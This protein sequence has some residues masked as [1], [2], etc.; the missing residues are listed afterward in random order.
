[1]AL[2]RATSVAQLGRAVGVAAGRLSVMVLS[3]GLAIALARI[4]PPAQRGEFAALQALTGLAAV[5]GNLAISGSI[6]YH[7]GKRMFPASRA[8]GAA[9]IWAFISGGIATAVLIPVALLLRSRLLPGISGSLLALAVVLAIPM[10]VR[11]YSG[12]VMIALS[13]PQRYL[14][15]H[16]VQPFGTIVF[17]AIFAIA[18]AT[19]F[20]HVV[21]AWAIAILGAGALAVVM[22]FS[23][24]HGPHAPTRAMVV[25][26]GRFGAR[27][28]VAV[29]TRFL[30]LRLDQF[31]VLALASAATL[32]QYAVAVNVGELLIQVSATML[33][34]LSGTISASG[35]EESGPI[36]AQYC[37]WA[38]IVVLVAAAAVAVVAP[39][40]IP[41]LFG[42]RYRPAIAS[43][44]LL[45]PGMV[46]YGPA[47]IITEYFVV[48]RGRPGKAAAIAGSSLVVSVILNFPLVPALGAAGASIASSISY[49]VM[50]LAATLMFHRDSGQSPRAVLGITGHDL[51]AVR[52]LIP[53]GTRSK[54]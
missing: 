17:L 30:N 13:R 49:G 31:L 46:C 36:V 22:S 37:R 15:T 20:S 16:A 52:Q 24:A 10:L 4:L 32:G 7:V 38:L 19:T 23:V 18:G 28:Y 44:W 9:V 34:A 45:L 51:R 40:A 25:E 2:G 29:L 1:M 35:R 27:T 11:E 48:Q 43:V 21:S 50:L 39:I 42:A 26:L 41:L 47:L 8:S 12:G 6:V 3:L 53:V 14:L 33:W 5:V 54:A